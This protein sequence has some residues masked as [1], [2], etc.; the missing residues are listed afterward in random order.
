M[1]YRHNLCGKLNKYIAT[2][3]KL[4]NIKDLSENSNAYLWVIVLVSGI[5]GLI[6][7]YRDR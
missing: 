4:Q 1:K 7:T 5:R 3:R 2:S 6:K